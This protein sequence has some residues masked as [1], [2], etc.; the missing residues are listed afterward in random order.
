[1]DRAPPCGIHRA[2]FVHRL[3]DDIDNA[4]ERPFADWNA[5]RRTGVL[6]GLSAYE[7]FGCVHRYGAHRRFAKMLCHFKDQPLAAVLRFERVQN[8]R[9]MAFEMHVHHRAHHLGHPAHPTSFRYCIH[10]FLHQSASAPEM[11]SIS[12]LVIIACRVRLYCSVRLSITSP[13][14]RVAE[15][16]AAILAPN[17]PATF[18]SSARK[19]CTFTLRGKGSARMAPSSGSYS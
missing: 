3:A 2:G 15:S 13:A 7:A 4:A 8:L 16:I 12:S 18:S 14:L 10:G 9:Q 11:I 17:S 6:D 19:I 1:M 5:D